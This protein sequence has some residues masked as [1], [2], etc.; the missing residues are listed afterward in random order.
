MVGDG[1][2]L[3][4][5]SELA[6]SV[7]MGAKLIV[8][9]LDNRGF[10]CINRLQ[11]ATGGDSFNNLLAE[12]RPTIDFVAHARSL[13]ADAEKAAN[14]AELEAGDGARAALG[15]HLRHRHRHRPGARAPRPAARGGTSRCP[16]CRSARR[17]R[18]RA[19]TTTSRFERCGREHPF[20]R[21][22]DRLDQRRHARTGR[23]HAAGNHARGHPRHRLR[24]RR[25]GRQIPA[26][27]GRAEALARTPTA[28]T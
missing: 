25:A 6:T 18:R 4:L 14:L 8:V 27:S 22:P 12:R 19:R 3:M 28:S 24:R 13:G 16:K 21:Q 9:L 2:Y 20:R 23:R 15:P 5:N 26:R 10:G 17:S 7:M 11:Q 1:S